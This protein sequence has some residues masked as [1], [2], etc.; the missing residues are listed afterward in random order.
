M[1]INKIKAI[2]F[3]NII[4]YNKISFLPFEYGIPDFEKGNKFVNSPSK[5]WKLFKGY[6]NGI[7]KEMITASNNS[8]SLFITLV[9][10]NRKLLFNGSIELLLMGHIQMK[11][12][13][14]GNKILYQK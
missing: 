6:S 9:K 12:G 4:F 3:L 1:L 13:G 14:V 5:F 10:Y 11:N 7:E 8:F 2:L